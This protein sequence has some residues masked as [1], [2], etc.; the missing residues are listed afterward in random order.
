[1]EREHGE[2]GERAWRE[3]MER[4]NGDQERIKNESRTKGEEYQEH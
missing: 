4:E 2:H 3:S 1:M